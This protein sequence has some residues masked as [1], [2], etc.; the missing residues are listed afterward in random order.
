M[1]T[2]VL[3]DRLPGIDLI[4]D[5]RTIDVLP[6]CDVVTAG[7]PC[8]DLSQAG[9]TQGIRGENS[10]LVSKVLDI[11]RDTPRK[12]T[13]LILENVPFMLNLDRGR[14]MRFITDRLG[15]M[16][17]RWAYPNGQY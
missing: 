11:L 13:W 2:R 10:G 17:W 14:A 6:N 8:Q 9:R 15:V 7:F 5:V 16:G 1:A 12:P 4:Q 3:A